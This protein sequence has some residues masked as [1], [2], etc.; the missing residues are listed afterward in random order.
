MS[1]NLDQ[2]SDQPR[3]SGRSNRTA[4]SYRSRPLRG[5]D[6]FL[7]DISLAHSH[8]STGLGGHSP[9]AGRPYAIERSPRCHTA[10]R[11]AQIT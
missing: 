3:G 7:D 9:L 1:Q 8:H 6:E 4:L 10:S 2:L 5:P 11:G